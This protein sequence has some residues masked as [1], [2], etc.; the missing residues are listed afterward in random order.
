MDYVTVKPHD[1]EVYV[2]FR[3]LVELDTNFPET[4]LSKTLLQQCSSDIT[5]RLAPTPPFSPIQAVCK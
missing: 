2:G 1:E 4:Y 5:A 3:L